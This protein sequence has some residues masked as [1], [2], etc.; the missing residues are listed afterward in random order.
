MR[1]LLLTCLAFPLLAQAAG[2]APS[3]ELSSGPSRIY[4]ERLTDRQDLNFEI[5][6]A[7]TSDLPLE[8]STIQVSAYDAGG[9]LLQRRLIDGNGVRPSIQMVPDRKLA[10]H[11]K[12][13]VFNPF[14]SFGTELPL[15]RLDYQ[16]TLA[17]ED[18]KSTATRSLQV[19]P[20]SFQGKTALRL[21]MRGRVV[22]YDGHDLQAHHRRFDYSFAPIAQMG[23][24][25]N[26][27]R[28]SYDFVPVNAK[29]EMHRGDGKRNEDYPGF[30]SPLLAAG[31][32]VVVAVVND[33]P[34]DR[35]F[36]QRQIASNPM[37]LFGNYLVIDHGNGEF[38]VYGHLK[39]GSVRVKLGQKLRQGEAVAQIGASGS[40]MFPHLHYE[41]QDGADTSA[42]GLPSYF[43]GTRRVL[44]GSTVPRA[45]ATVDTGEI[46]ESD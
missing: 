33:R 39:Q 37:V 29:G 19:T 2:P 12:L 24:K 38:S 36:D 1:P 8:I 35:Q 44:G 40:A 17:T 9:Q 41:L 7:N 21:P 32:G 18:G 26:F 42:E 10:A 14:A 34:D 27:M 25:S 31:D 13:T 4:L 3:F 45:L 28:Y 23:F 43:C 6:I 11:G 5:F 20:Q 30:G 22:N 16:V 15:A 46:V